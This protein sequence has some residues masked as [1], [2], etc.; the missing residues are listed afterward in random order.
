MVLNAS[1]LGYISNSNEVD[2]SWFSMHFLIFDFA[3][4]VVTFA[5][6]EITVFEDYNYLASCFSFPANA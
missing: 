5:E 2:V 3:V 1:Q 4:V 6:E